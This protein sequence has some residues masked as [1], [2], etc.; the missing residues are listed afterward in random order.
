MKEMTIEEARTRF[1]EMV[2]IAADAHETVVVARDGSPAV[3]VI[4]YWEYE[5]MRRDRSEQW[6]RSTEAVERFHRYLRENGI[7]FS[8]IDVTQ[9]IHDMREERDAQ[10]LEA[11]GLKL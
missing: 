11:I 3:A 5:V 7:D 4:P 1:D 8:G 6:R 9:M 10:L 2:G